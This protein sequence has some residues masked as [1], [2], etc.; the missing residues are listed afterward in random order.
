ME[1][2]NQDDLNESSNVQIVSQG[3]MKEEN[4]N[5]AVCSTSD[6]KYAAPTGLREIGGS[7]YIMAQHFTDLWAT[8]CQR[9]KEISEEGAVTSD[10]FIEA[11]GFFTND[12]RFQTSHRKKQKG[13]SEFMLRDFFISLQGTNQRNVYQNEV[14]PGIINLVL[15]TNTL[16]PNGK[17]F[18]LLRQ[19]SNQRITLS[20]RQCACL[21]AHMVMCITRDQE[22]NKLAELINFSVIYGKAGLAKNVARKIHKIK[23]IFTYFEKF[24]KDKESQ[25]GE[26]IFE[27]SFLEGDHTEKEWMD[28]D[29]TLTRADIQPEGSIEDTRDALQVVFSDKQLGDQ[30]LQLPTTQQQIMS[31][32]H[33]ELILSILFCEELKLDEA[34]RVYG[35]GRFSNYKGYGDSFEFVGPFGEDV[36]RRQHVIMDAE[37]YHSKQ[38]ASQFHENCVLRELNKAYAGF[39]TE[40]I[41][42]GDRKKVATGKWGCGVFR[43]NPQL[44]FM[45]QW[46]AASRAGREIVFYTYNDAVTFG[47]EDVNKILGYYQGKEVADLFKDLEKA[48]REMQT[49][50]DGIDDENKNLFKVLILQLGL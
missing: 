7:A 21:L 42:E 47:L 19:D 22:N 28:C 6:Q 13:P 49:E 24:F 44:K 37:K 20:K 32:I 45:I 35:A 16:F 25:E 46:L 11:I 26:V 17:T 41:E 4:M 1:N 39:Q 8:I 10:D 31:L 29:E 14:L 48:T 5:R 9:L 34:V 50:N 23:C 43:G 3:E 12:E 33:P 36:D 2:L 27:R 40:N 38:A 18:P 15:E 30:V